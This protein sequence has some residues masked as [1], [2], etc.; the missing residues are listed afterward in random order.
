[1]AVNHGGKKISS[2]LGTIWLSSLFTYL[3]L[4]TITYAGG[5][6]PLI[7]SVCIIAIVL[8]IISS[9]LLVAIFVRS[10]WRTRSKAPDAS[11]PAMLR[12]FTA[13]VSGLLGG[14]AAHQVN[15]LFPGSHTYH[16]EWLPCLLLFS[17]IGMLVGTVPLAFTL[18]P[19]TTAFLAWIV[20]AAF[21]WFIIVNNFR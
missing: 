19:R 18:K 17:L 6:P 9:V 11:R 2:V 3:L 7:V 14:V 20:S 12:W 4:G 10:I 1:M 16:G 15:H 13:V 21:S 8:W 5:M